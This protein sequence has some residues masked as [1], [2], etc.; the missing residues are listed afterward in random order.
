MAVESVRLTGLLL[1]AVLALADGVTSP[2]TRARPKA[3]ELSAHLA[4]QIEALIATSPAIARG[5]IGFK[6]ADADTGA[7]LVEHDASHFFTPA[8]NAKLYTTALALVRLGPGYQF[9]T[10]LRTGK[11]WH[12][13]Q[14]TV[15]D[16]QLVGGGDPNLSGRA[17]PYQVDAPE[18]DQLAALKQLADKVSDQGIR[19]VAGDVTGVAG[20]YGN[21][22]YPDGW[23]L[24]DSIYSYG[25]PVSSL[26]LNDNSLAVILRP[27]ELGELA[28]VELR[29]GVSHFAIQNQVA[30][31]ASEAAHVKI[32]RPAGSNEIV[33]TGT[34]G[35]R[36]SQWREDVAVDNAALFTAEA[37]VDLLRERGIAVGGSARAQYERTSPEAATGTLLG[38]QLSHPLS[39]IVQIVNKVSQNLHAE[40]LLREVALLRTG[41]GSQ[42]NGAKEREAFLNEAGI[43]REG[44]GY[45]ID[46]GSGLARQD[47]TT[48][49]STVALL[50]WMWARPERE[51]W[52]NTL[53]IGGLDG[54]LQHRFR[55]VAGA[56]RVRAKTGLLS[57]VNTLSGYIETR[58][59]GSIAFSIMV[60]GTAGHDVDVRDFIDKLCA[61]FL[62]L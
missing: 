20:R 16:L 33:L 52:V 47:L 45:A 14:D 28:D 35:Q 6:F 9:R 38:E 21:E 37:F 24:D 53:P 54:S 57:H 55:N 5:R 46:D 42:E 59:H 30:T 31:N 3:E 34:I 29:P 7:V 13:G 11:S 61:V 22:A 39:E 19:R 2:K 50:R 26:C 41:T 60:N 15:A 44:T 4:R 58:E 12:T 40:I 10:E 48:P 1:L 17:L 62:P 49:D 43:S 23:T 27:T 56:G 8:S 18:G 25:A 32:S 36:V 51:V